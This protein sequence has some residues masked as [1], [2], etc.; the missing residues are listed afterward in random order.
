[1]YSDTLI[2]MTRNVNVLVYNMILVHRQNRTR[3]EGLVEN[4]LCTSNQ[5][6]TEVTTVE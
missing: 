6:T 3:R 2:Y 1:M 5:I 4:I